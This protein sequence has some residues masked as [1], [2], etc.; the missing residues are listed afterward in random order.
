M[1]ASI[2]QL[3]GDNLDVAAVLAYARRG[4]VGAAVVILVFGLALGRFHREHSRAC[5]GQVFGY[6]VGDDEVPV[7]QPLHQGAGPQAVGTMIGKIGFSQ[8]E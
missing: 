3:I 8:D 6:G 2:S 4:E 5:L 1:L 7:G